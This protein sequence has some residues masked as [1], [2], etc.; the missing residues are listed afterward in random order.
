[1]A[2]KGNATKQLLLKIG[3]VFFGI[4]LALLMA[5]VIVRT[6]FEEPIQPRFVI[7]PGYGVQANQPNVVT[8]YYFPEDYAVTIS[9]NSM[10]M[11]GLREYSIEKAPNVHRIALLGDS[12][13]Y[14]IGV[15]DEEVISTLLEDELR[16]TSQQHGVDFEV[17]NFAVT[18]FG[19][20]EELVT[21]QQSVKS[22]QPDE[23][24]IFYYNNDIRNNA[25]TKLFEI[26][27]D[28]ILRR[29][30]SQYLPGVKAREVLYSIAP[31]RWLFKHSQ[32]W[33]L[34]RQRLSLFIQTAL[35]KKQGFKRFDETTP[36]AV[37]LTRALL[38]RLI[39]EIKLDGAH[40][41]IF[42]IPNNKRQ[43]NFP[44]T[45]EEVTAAGA[46][47]IDGREFLERRDY[48][49]RDQHWRASGHQKAEAK[50]ADS[51]RSRN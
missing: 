41:T 31:T 6:F 2:P 18:G 5:E 12:F 50:L 30:N 44:L 32:V 19:Q 49:N 27:G 21:Y 34:I 23:V 43:S 39:E 40:P 47:L 46:T 17:L 14:G 42:I 36:R 37:E 3:L 11:R 51:I 38:K 33:N 9:N 7:D 15:N 16:D 10:G 22:Y 45:P 25:Q 26:D 1:M 4:A 8:R 24:V 48:Y 20:T 35:L 29:T 13:I 28:G